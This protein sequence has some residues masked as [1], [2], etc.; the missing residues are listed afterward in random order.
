MPNDREG[1]ANRRPRRALVDK[2]RRKI[3]RALAVGDAAED[4]AKAAQAVLMAAE[5][6]QLV[7]DSMDLSALRAALGR[8]RDVHDAP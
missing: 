8:Y 4:L 6:E 3:E 1:A 7:L 5:A 2:M